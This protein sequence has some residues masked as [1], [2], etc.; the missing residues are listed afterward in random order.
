MTNREIAE[1]GRRSV[2][3]ERQRRGAFDVT[4]YKK[5]RQTE[6]RA[7]DMGR[8]RTVIIRVKTKTRGNW[9]ATINESASAG[10][11]D[12]TDNDRFWVLVDLGPTGAGPTKYF[13]MPDGWIR[14][15]IKE[16]YDW[17]LEIHGGRRPVTPGSPHVAIEPQAIEEW[18][19]A[20][21]VLGIF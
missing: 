11:R 15:H 1:M 9:H 16:H 5:G 2:A 14:R 7:S 6:L 17:W 13:V 3:D 10:E 20:W 18:Q 8:T 19:D 21:N 12:R 4:H